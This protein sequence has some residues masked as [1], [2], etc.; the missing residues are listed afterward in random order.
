MNNPASISVIV[1]TLGRPRLAEAL[2]SVAAQT[3]P[4]V[5]AV[6]V[7][8]SGGASAP[9]IKASPGRIL[10]VDVGHP[11]NRSAALNLGIERT[12]ADVIAIL[13][14]D[15]CYEPAHL[16]SLVEGLRATGADLVYSGVQLRT[17]TPD[18]R[19][20]HAARVERDYDF[21]HLVFGNYIYACSIAFTKSTW[22]S[23]GGYDTRF[24]VY[25]DWDFY[26]RVGARGRIARVD[27]FGAISRKFTGVAGT[28]PHEAERADVT[29]CQHG[30]HWKHRKLIA[31]NALGSRAD[32]LYKMYPH[33]APRGVRCQT[34]KHVAG[35]WLK[36]FTA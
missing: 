1:R 18:G 22:R 12:S 27:G 11:L 19:P 14:D 35:W 16:A 15:N 20:L 31:R 36:G 3:L 17:F 24:P 21:L 9:V 13:D 28:S 26:I 8:M 23:V 29:R 6:V 4:G 32:D 7:D 5:E 33:V 34:L 25:E 10:H 2:A 30:I